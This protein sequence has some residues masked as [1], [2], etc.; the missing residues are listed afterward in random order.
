M[1]QPSAITAWLKPGFEYFGSR[2]GRPAVLCYQRVGLRMLWNGCCLVSPK[3]S[4]FRYL[5]NRQPSWLLLLPCLICGIL[6]SVASRIIRSNKLVQ[7]KAL[8]NNIMP[9]VNG[10]FPDFVLL[11]RVTAILQYLRFGL[12]GIVI[13]ILVA[14]TLVIPKPGASLSIIT[15]M[16]AV[17]SASFSMWY[18]VAKPKFIW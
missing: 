9:S 11:Q 2:R 6:K 14:L 3:N 16:V 13:Y 1:I 17:R 8:L 4:S 10:A 15:G 18:S 12:S 5:S 7:R